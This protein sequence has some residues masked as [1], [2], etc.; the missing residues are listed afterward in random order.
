MTLSADIKYKQKILIVD[1][2]PNNLQ[3]LFKY[4]KNS[5]YQVL[6]AQNGK[7]AI[8][9]AKKS[10]PDLILLDIM[11]PGISGFDVCKQLKADSNTQNIPIIF[12]TALAQTDNKVKGLALGAVDYITKPI[13]QEE[14]LARLDTH[15]TLQNLNQHLKLEAQQQK[16]LF[17]I[18][19]RIRKSLDLKSIFQ[20]ATDEIHSFLQ[21]DRVSIAH[22]DQQNIYF[23]FKSITP[24]IN[25]ELPQKIAVDY[26]CQNQA[27][28]DHYQQGGIYAI[29]NIAN[30]KSNTE[31]EKILTKLQVKSQLIVPILQETNTKVANNYNALWGWIV[32][33]K[34][35][36]NNH[37]QANYSRKW[38]QR[39]TDLL[40]LLANQLSIAIQQGSLH[41]QLQKSHEKLKK[42]A[43]CDSLTQVFNRRYFDQ[44]LNLEWRRLK[45]MPSPLSL[46]M[47]DVDC[48][49]IYNDT[50][51]H[52]KGDECLRQIANTIS[53]I[54][55]RPADI[56]ARYGG[57]EFVIILPHTT[58]EGAIKVAEE[59]RVVVKE[60]N[61]PHLN[62][63]VNSVVTI[64]AGVA[65][66]TPNS[67]DDPSLLVE[68]ADQALY[69]AKNRGR[70]CV[71]A[72]HHDISQSK[73]QQNEDILWNKRIRKAL[74]NNLF[75]LYAQSITTLRLDDKR[76]HF[77]ILLRLTDTEN[78]VIS[79][80]IFLDVAN[81]NSL[82]PQIDT[83]VIKNLFTRLAESEP[84][85]WENYHFSINL[86]GAS[87]NKEG[88]LKFLLQKI[89]DSHLP[90]NL[91]CFE[92]TETIAISNLTKVSKFIKSL[93]DL[94]CS[95]AL[96][97]FGTGMSSLNYLKILPVDYLKIDGS[98]ITE[99]NKDQVSKAMVEG[100]NY[101]AGAIG[102]KTVAEFVENQAIF[103]TVRDLQV[104]YAQGYHLGRP[105]ELTDILGL[106]N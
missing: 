24:N 25:I 84:S 70:D 95:F 104:D 98:F 11:M 12:M 105:G 88:F 52:R 101:L 81:R 59:M 80:N 69:L 73:F 53:S 41:A 28:Y 17:E 100:I 8:E 10:S 26:L 43:L 92:I 48:F 65:S 61:I 29:D 20:T 3:L 60:L 2:T 47:C 87:L 13:E 96:D 16:L 72:Y 62:S 36:L 103:D 44:Q 27:E 55:K 38:D 14:L 102:L 6:V 54:I 22:L 99:L 93:R 67:N 42:L 21:C 51:G 58:L 37:S 89:K 85:Y 32:A 77:E 45:R 83:W 39:E 5:G 106:R 46:I 19:D 9:I 1:D 76:K 82:M 35:E 68:A 97:D 74:A 34:C 23:E 90:P 75:S 78:Q 50:Y 63:S 64:S 30:L 49:K 40:R 56:V 15:L 91:F 33:D 4:I 86:S 66:T 7:N 94:G 79:P 18:S 71:A 31:R 57:E